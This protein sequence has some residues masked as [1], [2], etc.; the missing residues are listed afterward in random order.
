MERNIA[1]LAF[2]DTKIWR[3]LMQRVNYTI[4]RVAIPYRKNY[5]DEYARNASTEYMDDIKM[6]RSAS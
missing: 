5:L 3:N 6:T 2:H 1:E 4:A